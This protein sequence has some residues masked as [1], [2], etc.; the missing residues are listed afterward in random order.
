MR[1]LNIELFENKE[2][3]IFLWVSYLAWELGFTFFL[4]LGRILAGDFL[5]DHLNSSFEN[6]SQLQNSVIVG[7][8]FIKLKDESFASFVDSQII[9][10]TPGSIVPELFPPDPAIA[11]FDFLELLHKFEVNSTDVEG[12]FEVGSFNCFAL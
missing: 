11:A 12:V 2:V 9:P 6:H 4:L 1:G 10:L 3:F 7:V 8:N 5:I